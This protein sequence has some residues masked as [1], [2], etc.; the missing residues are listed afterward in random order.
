M[1]GRRKWLINLLFLAILTGGTLLAMLR[2]RDLGDLLEILRDADDRW[3]IPGVGLMILFILGE[4]VV[5]HHMLRKMQSPLPFSRCALCSF[6]GFFFSCVT[7]FAGGGQPAQVLFLRKHGVSSAKAVPMLVLVTITYKLVLVVYG[8]AVFL[9]RPEPV[10]TALDSVRTWCLWG[11]LITSIV[12]GFLLLVILLPD[13]MEHLLRLPL[14]FL[15]RRFHRLR[16]KDLT[17]RLH[18]WMAQYRSA[19]GYLKDLKCLGWVMTVTLIQRTL[20]FL[21]SFLALRAF[22]VRFISPWAAALQQGMISLGTD[23]LPLP[24]GT[25]AN[26]TMFLSL[27]TP[28]LGET[29]LPVLLMCRGISYYAQLLITAVFTAIALTRQKKHDR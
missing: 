23:L 9:L 15:Q 19:A 27:Y 21:V 7:P 12:V 26:E 4:S 10:W 3:L 22:G 20:L 24:G 6:V 25:G 18:I 29:A 1:K 5:I 11:F 2:G 13:A 14:V 17:G 28:L 8:A 16:E